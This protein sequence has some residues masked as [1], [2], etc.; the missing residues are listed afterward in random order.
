MTLTIHPGTVNGNVVAAPSKSYTHR[1]FFLGLLSDGTTRVL[2]A[3]LSEDTRAT[4]QAVEALGALVER[5]ESIDITSDGSVRTPENVIDC[6]NSGTTLR[7]V[8]AIASLAPGSAVLTGDASLRK[9]PMKP[10]LDALASVGVRAESTRDNGCAPVVVHGPLRG[11]K[12]MLPGDVSSQFV[13]ALLLAGTR[14]ANGIDIH[15]QGELKSR[16]YVDITREMVEDFG[17]RIEEP[18]RGH[19]H[20]PGDQ[21]LK[22]REYR[23]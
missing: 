22:A 15:I 2:E 23:V 19:F 7:L 4:L 1:A 9:R 21:R 8:S 12:T 6:L 16:P 14:T 11:G 13:S 10:L 20:A 5:T 17:G 3:L 18:T